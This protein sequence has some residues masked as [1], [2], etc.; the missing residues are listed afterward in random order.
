MELDNK[1]SS[2]IVLHG[3]GAAPGIAIGCACLFSKNVPQIIERT[4]HDE[5]I[6][7]EIERLRSA[8]ERSQKELRKIL[9]FAEQKLGDRTKILEAQMMV[10]EDPILL[11]TLYNRIRNEK[12]NAEIIVSG[13]I[14]KYQQ[15]M[16]TAHDEYMHERAHDMDD[17]KL[18]IV[19]C[20]Q[21][22]KLI[23]KI[24]RGCIIVSHNLTSADTVILSRN[25]TLAYVTD[26][27]GITS[28]AALFSRSL[29]IPAVVGLK[30]ATRF[31]QNKV[32]M[33]VDSYSGTVIIN[34][35]PQRISEYESKRKAYME[36][37]RKLSGLRELPAET[38]DGKRIELAANIDGEEEIEFSLLQ[39]ADGVG[40]LRTENL[41]VGSEMLPSEEEQYS[42]YKKIS[43]KMYPHKVVIRTFDV[44]GDKI[45]PNSIEEANPFLGWRG[46][47]VS[48]DD[49]DVF[50]TQLKA[51]LRASSRKNIYILLPM[52]ASL[53]EV[54]T[55]KLWLEKA[56]EE[57]YQEKI[58]FD[59]H[60][61][62]GAMIEVPSA[63]LLIEELAKELDFFSVGT[64]DLTQYMLA[65]DRGNPY[66]S[67][68]FNE[69][70]PAVLRSLHQIVTAAHKVGK[71]VSLCG[72]LG[73][74]P[75]AT[76][77]LLG[78]GFD[79]IS[80]EP[81]VLPEIKK[82]IRSLSLKEARSIAQTALH[83][84]TTRDIEQFLLG[85]LRK[86]FP[87]IAERL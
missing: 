81:S 34:P 39:G 21:A 20:L 12:K 58:R 33:I 86:E 16:L 8:L 53:E 80:V 15:L 56:K 72:A 45:A 38:S 4:L 67:N 60:I 40:L 63:V 66:V 32:P 57:L 42:I 10:L 76:S 61:Q 48:L 1:S 5:E 22:Q 26:L 73:S 23:S 11:E 13:E 79:S 54:R 55:S 44:G 51:M 24:E 43:D 84:T 2:E 75:L 59:K 47:R 85:I 87:E 37:E 83:F 36:H 3:I 69:L 46:I 50:L 78:L 7:T 25:E 14:E 70:H 9:L 41:I 64:N 18:R 19:R 68:L 62:L 6:D 17:L 52:I 27:G 65:V 71:W 82:I 49:T 28:H 29:N 31:V 74:N 30:D 35:S 77:I